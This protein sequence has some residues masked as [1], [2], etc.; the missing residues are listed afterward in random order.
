M[1]SLRTYLLHAYYRQQRIEYRHYKQRGQRRRFDRNPNGTF[2]Y[3]DLMACLNAEKCPLDTATAAN[4]RFLHDLRNEIEHHMPP[5]LD[6]Y[7]GSR[8]LACALNFEY[9]LTTLFGPKLSLQQHVALALQFG[10][11]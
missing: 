5:G 7:L 4:L 1:A 3:W 2:R 10:D 9:W 11:V 6:D 8:Y